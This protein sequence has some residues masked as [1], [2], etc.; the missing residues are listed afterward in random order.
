MGALPRTAGAGASD[1]HRARRLARAQ[2]HRARAQRGRV[3]R[4][5]AG[6]GR[7][8]AAGAGRVAVHD[9]AAAAAADRVERHGLRADRRSPAGAKRRR[10][11]RAARATVKHFRCTSRHA[12]NRAAFPRSG[13]G[14]QAPVRRLAGSGARSEPEC[15][16]GR[17][18]GLAAI[19][20]AGRRCAR[21]VGPAHGHVPDR[22][23]HDDARRLQPVV[24]PRLHST[25]EAS[26]GAA[27]LL[28]Q[29]LPV[30]SVVAPS[31]RGASPV[32]VRRRGFTT[33]C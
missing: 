17:S 15:L 18:A 32:S 20:R 4:G 3:R 14:Q 23:R 21:A 26:S 16:D 33:G 13:P 8:P 5:G 25:G 22:S 19:S 31:P 24:K 9:V 28:A 27:L 10:R 29:I 11:H 6:P 30:F 2:G 7:R 12:I 1:A